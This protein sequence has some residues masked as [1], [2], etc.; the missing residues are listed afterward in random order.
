MNPNEGG[1][2]FTVRSTHSAPQGK[3]IPSSPSPGIAALQCGRFFTGW[4]TGMLWIKMWRTT[5]LEQDRKLETQRSTL[6]WTYKRADQK[7]QKTHHTIKSVPAYQTDLHGYT[8]LLRPLIY[9]SNT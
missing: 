8:K 6:K 3:Y 5:V 1:G 9:N 4:C 7:K 2:L